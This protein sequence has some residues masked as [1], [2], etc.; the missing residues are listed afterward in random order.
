MISLG[1]NC[2]SSLGYGCSSLASAESGG[3]GTF[4]GSSGLLVALFAL[5][6]GGG[7][8]SLLLESGRHDVGRESYVA[9]T[10]RKRS[11]KVL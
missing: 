5:H 4:F 10:W 2:S 9:V 6:L 8:G 1:I 7:G 3:S 11:Y